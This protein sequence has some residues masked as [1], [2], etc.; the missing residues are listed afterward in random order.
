MLAQA[1]ATT[2]DPAITYSRADMENLELA[3]GSFDLAYSSLAL[4]YVEMSKTWTG[5][6]E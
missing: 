4:H 6:W 1:R 3:A 2:Q 5:W